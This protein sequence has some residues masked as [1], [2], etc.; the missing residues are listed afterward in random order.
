MEEVAELCDRTIFLK[1][2]II[3]ADDLP[4]NLAKSVSKYQLRLTITDGMKR[5]VSLAEK[6]NLVYQLDHRT[7][8]ISIDETEI[9]AFLQALMQEG[10]SYA[11]IQIKE[12]SLEDYFLKI[13][14]KTI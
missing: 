8:Q 9:P 4:K 3:I 11:G 1:K 6:E 2:G 7:I 10:V 5:T 13:V 12:P 14:E